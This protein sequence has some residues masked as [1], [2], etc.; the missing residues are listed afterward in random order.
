[1]ATTS[2][3]ADPGFRPAN[4]ASPAE[5]ATFLP[6]LRPNLALGE[7]RLTQLLGRGGMGEVYRAVHLRLDRPVAI[8]V[9]APARLADPAAVARFAREL[10]AI[11]RLDHPNLVRATDAGE[12]GPWHFLV[13]EL[14]DGVDLR[15]LVQH[16]G[17]LASA[18]ACELT[19]QAAEGLQYGHE[20]GIV[21]RDLKPSNLMLT[22]A[23]VVKLLDLGL[24]RV[25]EA[26]GL[27]DTSLT[28]TGQPM[29]TPD[30]MAPEQCSSARAATA[31][32]DLYSLGCTLYFLLAGRPPFHGADSYP[33]KLH[34]HRYEPVPPLGTARPDLP[35]EL[36]AL[37]DRLLA[38]DPADR[39]ESAVQVADELVVWSTAADLSGLVQR[40][41]TDQQQI[42][43]SLIEANGVDRPPEVVREWLNEA[44]AS[45][46]NEGAA[47]PAAEP[48]LPVETS[49][50]E[51]PWLLSEGRVPQGSAASS[52][53]GGKSSFAGTKGLVLTSV[54]SLVVLG[55]L[56]FI[57]PRLE[58]YWAHRAMLSALS[59]EPR[60]IGLPPAARLMLQAGHWVI[61]RIAVLVVLAVTPLVVVW[62]MRSS[63]AP[64]GPKE[65]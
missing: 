26:D 16:S 2:D 56:Y 29:G 11:G 33:S 38:K 23:G 15:T 35:I 14:L 59:S 48:L 49:A 64:D 55:F 47:V 62:L 34:A 58:A 43:M 18:D 13:M 22:S 5:T 36:I 17:P 31:R 39:P 30:Y 51:R 63:A 8:K 50:S 1:M 24:A 42:L 21:H 41:G 20:Q 65:K 46:P 19:R 37:V 54:A 61:R 45:G 10:R 57:A 27:D 3:E 28:S 44:Q 32:T 6:V 4:P 9:L 7:Y 52:T 25:T 60:A 12:H 53:L 40:C